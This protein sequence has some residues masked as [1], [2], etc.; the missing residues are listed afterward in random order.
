MTL[1]LNPC[2]CLRGGKCT[3]CE[4]VKKPAPK[5]FP[6][7][8]GTAPKAG[9]EAPHGAEG[10]SCCGTS[11]SEARA[12]PSTAWADD[13]H[14]DILV[15]PEASTQDST[16]AS[17]FASTS[18]YIEPS[19]NVAWSAATDL[20][21][22]LSANPLPV[23]GPSHPSSS[24]TSSLAS[25]PALLPTPPLFLPPTAG[26]LACFCGPTCACV[27][28]ATHDPHARKR[29][30]PGA[31]G[32]GGCQ[33]GT[34]RGC[35]EGRISTKKSRTSE[36]AGDGGGCC[37]SKAGER[38]AEAGG[39]GPSTS[40]SSRAEKTA[41]TPPL[42]QGP[43]PGSAGVSLPSLWSPAAL[44]SEPD[45]SLPAVVSA[46]D[47]SSAALTAA[48]ASE[49]LPSL[50][51]LWPALLEV[52]PTEG[53]DAPA[54]G[55]SSDRVGS[56]VHY[57]LPRALLDPSLEPTILRAPELDVQDSAPVPIPSTSTAESPPASEAPAPAAPPPP[58]LARNNRLV[59]T[60]CSA[61]FLEEPLDDTC[62]GEVLAEAADGE[63]EEQQGCECTS[64]CDCREKAREKR[65]S[66]EGD[67]E[68]AKSGREGAK[69]GSGEAV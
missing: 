28:C 60:A 34:G 22:S 47:T 14:G 53:P 42:L 15:T 43:P 20:P 65:R 57:E 62:G 23:P 25:S 46:S 29:P 67:G 55:D 6:D 45:W 69:E 33:C 61:C 50:R 56:P 9:Q 36:K 7:D 1:L 30:A 27:G 3:C 32:G 52:Q 8:V 58:P 16:A 5:F 13:A 11:A 2:N 4:S 31:C 64:R 38:R 24:A 39:S 68:R 17:S 49:P 63:G 66:Q 51:T 12:A 26:T 44:P 19:V 54:R 40:C 35:E 10:S 48:A 18:T 37:A 59:L 41:S 21:P